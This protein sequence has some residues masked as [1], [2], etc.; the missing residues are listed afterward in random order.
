MSVIRFKQF[1]KEKM[2]WV[3]CDGKIKTF[4]GFKNRRAIDIFCH[5]IFL[6]RLG[7]DIVLHK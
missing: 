5:D 4:V 2:V 1:Y 7:L 3:Y 6:L